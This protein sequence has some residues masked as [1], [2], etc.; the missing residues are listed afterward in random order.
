MVFC[1]LEAALGQA[2]RQPI[3]LELA[4]ETKMSV[5]AVVPNLAPRSTSSTLQH[6]AHFPIESIPS[7]LLKALHRAM[8]IE[9]GR[10]FLE[11]WKQQALICCACCFV[12]LRTAAF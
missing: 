8:M 9:A 2:Q 12:C 7:I 3:E 5:A 10:R 1:V 6:V 11:A 4:D